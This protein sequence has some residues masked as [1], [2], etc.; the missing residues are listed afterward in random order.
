MIEAGAP[1][2][3]GNKGAE[4]VAGEGEKLNG[5]AGAGTV[6]DACDAKEKGAGLEDAGAVEGGDWVGARAGTDG[7]TE[8]AETVG[9]GIA[10]V[11]FPPSCCW[12]RLSF[13]R[14]R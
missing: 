9:A 11:P 1:A 14:D 5:F 7:A 3:P 4:A 13:G 8:V 12:L 10:A 6:D 2:N